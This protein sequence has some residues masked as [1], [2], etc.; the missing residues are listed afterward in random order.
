MKNK[1][2]NIVTSIALI[3][4]PAISFAQAP[5]L[6]T[7]ASFVLFSTAGAVTNVGVSHLTSKITGNVGTNSGSSTQFA[8]LHFQIEC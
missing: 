3:T 6:G 8:H 5:N 1:L 2:L 4:T 7:S